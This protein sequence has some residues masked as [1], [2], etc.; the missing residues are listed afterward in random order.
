MRGGLKINEE[1]KINKPSKIKTS[2]RVCSFYEFTFADFIDLQ[3]PTPTYHHSNLAI[4]L[5]QSY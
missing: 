5:F 2:L 1:I 3:Q 4:E